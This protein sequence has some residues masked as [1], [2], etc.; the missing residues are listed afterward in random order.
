M[1]L[2]VFVARGFR[3]NLRAQQVEARLHVRILVQPVLLGGL[4]CQRHV[5]ELLEQ[6]LALFLGRLGGRLARDSL[7]ERVDHRLVDLRAVHG[8]DRGGGRR[9]RGAAGLRRIAGRLGARRGAERDG[10]SKQ[11]CGFQ[12]SHR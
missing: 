9:R 1:C 7:Q 4:R 6:R 5:D 11:E 12:V 10:G 2:G 3:E 8:H